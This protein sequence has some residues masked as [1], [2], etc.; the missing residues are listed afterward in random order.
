MIRHLPILAS[1][2]L[3]AG[4]ATPS[5]RIG[6]EL[7]RYGLTPQQAACVGGHLATNLSIGQLQQ[8]ARAARSYKQGDSNPG[9]LTASDLLRVSS[10]IQDPKV[11]I[12][13]LRA[14]AKC[15]VTGG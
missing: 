15:R 12:E 11:A 5:A 7:V 2:L 14:A 13:A 9:A 1:L 8:L 3:A 10:Q 6:D 4:C